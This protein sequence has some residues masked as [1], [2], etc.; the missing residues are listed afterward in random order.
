MNCSSSLKRY[1]RYSCL[2]YLG[3]PVCS[4]SNAIA[5]RSLEQCDYVH[6]YGRVLFE[7]KRVLQLTCSRQYLKKWGHVSVVIIY[8]FIAVI[9]TSSC[10]R[11]I[12]VRFN[13]ISK[14]CCLGKHITASFNYIGT[15]MFHSYFVGQ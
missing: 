4:S 11:D 2:K 9:C 10:S 12:S 14:Y 6:V 8:K 7:Y 15:C 3:L 5:D 13:F 1:N